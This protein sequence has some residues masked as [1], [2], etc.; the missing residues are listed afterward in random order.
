MKPI[1]SF[2]YEKVKTLG[3]E[4]K[5]L[6]GVFD[7]FDDQENQDEPQFRKVKNARA[8]AKRA[9]NLWKNKYTALFGDWLIVL[10]SDNQILRLYDSQDI[11]KDLEYDDH[12]VPF[13]MVEK[14]DGIIG[15][16]YNFSRQDLQL[17][18]KEW[19]RLGK[20]I[21]TRSVN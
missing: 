7:E 6:Q 1:T 10:Y 18:L 16:I 15:C 20:I 17:K 9:S 2:W 13:I 3:Q 5:Y 12:V 14:L 11:P 21:M 4:A 19:S 8:N